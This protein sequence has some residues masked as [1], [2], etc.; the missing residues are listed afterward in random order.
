MLDEIERHPEQWEMRYRHH[1]LPSVGPLPRSGKDDL[2]D[3]SAHSGRVIGTLVHR[4]LEMGPELILADGARRQWLLAQTGM[5]LSKDYAAD[6]DGPSQ[7]ANDQR[8]HLPQ[9]LAAQ[10]D[11]I[12]QR[13]GPEHPFRD[14]LNVPG[15]SEVDFTIVISNWTITGRF[16]RLNR[17]RDT[18]EIIDW[19][20]DSD[21]IATIVRRYE[22]QMELYAL[23]LARALT[24]GC[25]ADPIV[26]HLAMT[27]H[28][29]VRRLEF[30]HENLYEFEAR[31]AERLKSIS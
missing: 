29:Q 3:V 10:A 14:L 19:K 18:L 30:P 4:A 27:H 6:P 22:Q 25:R 2:S 15:D 13:I 7:E 31:L 1:L 26:V 24:N 8:K 23:A 11:E 17:A 21:D 9:A 20:T 16:D 28:A 12:L 5:L